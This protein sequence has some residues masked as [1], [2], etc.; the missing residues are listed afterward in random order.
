MAAHC[1]ARTMQ[2]PPE[3]Q[4]TID[5]SAKKTGASAPVFVTLCDPAGRTGKDH[6]AVADSVASAYADIGT[7][8][9]MMLRSP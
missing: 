9:H 4:T 1:A 2:R 7:H 5:N 3:R 8:E 6:A